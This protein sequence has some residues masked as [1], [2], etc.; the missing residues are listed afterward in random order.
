MPYQ[1]KGGMFAACQHRLRNCIA[2]PFD[3]MKVIKKYPDGTKAVRC[4]K[5]K[6][7]EA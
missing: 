1:P 2:L 4:D 3:Q 7:Q 5:F 6:R